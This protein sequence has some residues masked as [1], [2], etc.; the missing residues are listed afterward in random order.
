[1][2]HGLE[3]LLEAEQEVEGLASK[4]APQDILFGKLRPYLAKVALAVAHGICST[5]LLVYRSKSGQPNFFKY[6]LG[7]KLFIELVNSST[8]GS[9]MPRASADFIGIQEFH[10]HQKLK[11][12]L[13]PISSMKKQLRSMK[14]LP[15][16]KSKLNC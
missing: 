9:K 3:E 14:R 6:L 1:M 4:F 2:N 10:F 5:E 11:E 16:N 8:Y 7:S 13:S 12:Y 15:S